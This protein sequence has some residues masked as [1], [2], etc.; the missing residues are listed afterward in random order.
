MKSKGSGQGSQ[1]LSKKETMAALKEEQER[2]KNMQADDRT[3]ALED[4]KR[5]G[6]KAF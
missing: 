1:K 5:Q 4:M 6:D 2:Q 3:R